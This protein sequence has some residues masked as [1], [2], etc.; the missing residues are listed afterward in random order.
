M[1]EIYDDGGLRDEIDI[2]NK[3]KAY[4]F[5]HLTDIELAVRFCEIKSNFDI[6][7]FLLK[8]NYENDELIN[9]TLLTAVRNTDL[10]SCINAIKLLLSYGADINCIDYKHTP[11]M[12]ICSSSYKKSKKRIIKFLLDCGADPNME[13]ED[14]RNALTLLCEKKGSK[15]YIKIIKLLIKYKANVNNLNSNYWSCLLFAVENSYYKIAKLLLKNGADVNYITDKSENE[16]ILNLACFWR[17]NEKNDKLIKLLIDNDADVTNKNIFGETSLSN[18][19]KYATTYDDFE[20][21]KLLIKKGIEINY[22]NNNSKTLLMMCYESENHKKIF[23]YELIKLLLDNKADI[24]V[25]DNNGCNIL[26]IVK[27]IKGF[28]SEI[29]S[30]IFNYKNIDGDLLCQFDISFIYCN[31]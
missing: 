29:Y 13:N 23:E 11:L 30:L 14:G 5:I 3:F 21:I 22:K 10:K 15:K 12:V 7:E 20:I 16:S 1:E 6:F 24:Y 9:I 18:L 17:Q 31:F 2:P 4:E 28:N 27:K 25:K 8:K 19:I 26:D